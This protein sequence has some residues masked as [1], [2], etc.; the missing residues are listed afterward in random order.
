[1]LTVASAV[2]SLLMLA[3]RAT[4]AVGTSPDLLVVLLLCIA[5]GAVADEWRKRDLRGL[6]RAHDRFRSVYAASGNA[7]LETDLSLR[8]A[9]CNVALSTLLDLPSAEL[10]G[11][12][13]PDLVADPHP[14]DVAWVAPLVTGELQRLEARWVL[15]GADGR[16]V[17]VRV[18]W[19]AIADESG[20]AVGLVCTIAD[21][22]EEIHAIDATRAA[23]ER[24]TA[25]FTHAPLGVME[26]VGDGRVL[27]A[28]AHLCRMLGYTQ[29]ELLAL[30]PRCLAVAEDATSI[31]RGIVQLA[32]GRGHT[33]ERTLI[34]KEGERLPVLLSTTILRD[35]AGRQDRLVSF[36][37]DL[38]EV[39]GQR[40]RLAAAVAELEVVKAQLSARQAFTEALLDTVDVGIVSCGAAGGDVER[41]RAERELL[42]LARTDAGLPPQTAAGQVDVL[43]EDGRRLPP[44]QYP[45]ARCLAG[46]NIGDVTLLLGPVGGP[47]KR[48]LIRGSQIVDQQGVVQGAVVALTDVTRLHD[49]SEQLTARQRLLSQAQRLGRLGGYEADPGTGEFRLSP[50]LCRLWGHE[51]V[52]PRQALLELMHPDDLSRTQPLLA[53]A[54]AEG[55]SCE[56]V[57]RIR[58]ATTGQ[59]RVLRYTMQVDRDAH[60]RPVRMH[61]THQDVTELTE[62][63]RSATA[64]NALFEAIL[65][66]TPDYTFVTDVSTGAVVYGAPGKSIAGISSEQLTDLGPA[67]LGALVHPDDQ[68]K[69]R[70]ANTTAQDA[71]D[72]Q[73]IQVR[74]RVRGSDEQWHWLSRRVTPFH[75]DPRT[76]RVT[77]VLGVVRDVSDVI[78]AE[79]KLTHAALHDPLT[80]LP[81]RALLMDRL[82]EALVRSRDTGRD[83]A[84]IFLDLDGFKRVN[85]TAGH[86]AGD[87][88]LR[89]TAARLRSVVR[90]RDTVARVGG[91]EF[92]ILVEP[93]D[94][95][96][97]EHP[98]EPGAASA[99]PPLDE[100]AALLGERIRTVMAQPFTVH[101]TDH[102][103]SASLGITLA[104]QSTGPRRSAQEVLVD[105]DTAMYRA[106]KRGKDRIEVF[107]HQ[108][109]TD[110]AERGRIERLLRQ[111]LDAATDACD[112]SDGIPT[113]RRCA[114]PRFGVAYQPLVR[115]GTGRLIGFEALAR[116]TDEHG[117]PVPPES[118]I[119][120]AEDTG[121]ITTLGLVVLD[122]ACAQLQQWRSVLP[123]GRALTMAVNLSAVQAQHV[124]LPDMILATLQR[125]DLEPGALVL[126]LTETALLEAAGSTL[127]M[128]GRL[129]TAGVTV[130]IDDFGTGYASLRYLTTLPVN[131]VKVDRSFTTGL[132]H[133]A[134]KTRIVQAITGLAHD[135]GLDCVVEG[136]ETTGQRAALPHDVILQGYLTG[137]PASATEIA[138]T[139]LTA[140]P[141]RGS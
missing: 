52:V 10:I 130:Y 107:E 7:I 36:V 138:P 93:A 19:A 88:V 134:T 116:L 6:Q 2:T 91:D 132:P 98:S 86:A 141:S 21:L 47:H 121:L 89:E 23:R 133:D 76:G 118:F 111:G 45:L 81:N 8:I 123:E 13:L 104:G 82:G 17:A 42:G 9:H 108:L 112:Q 84:V 103:V 62:A 4:G 73:V 126:E 125:Y 32:S 34:T 38:S 29:A 127:A 136:V 85:D 15:R 100:A 102:T 11:R 74:F 43:D 94:R 92:V 20:R 99:P 122:R 16:G 66:A 95:E 61:G 135:L 30:P 60:G 31:A 44:A 69:I 71:A 5:V 140:G 41:N 18:A 14:L 119:A 70:A 49:L 83:C 77:E 26:T 115:N 137:A 106:K 113:P 128:L 37:L 53:A 101:G 35:P 63:E 57:F 97:P 33:A 80:E 3:A 129:R 46:E 40:D 96:H 12:A 25:L 75:R 67:A 54:L 27:S 114:A 87:Q 55:R 120:V 51:Q 68:S 139:R 50:E 65:T 48:V 124:N 64:A 90:D 117:N 56:G 78:E 28:N 72:G 58:H 59:E 110:L 39:H 79:D 109:R 105:A 1:V 131:G 22:S 24:A